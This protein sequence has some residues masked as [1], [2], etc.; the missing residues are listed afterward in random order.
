M[1]ILALPSPTTTSALSRGAH[2]LL[3]VL[4]ENITSSRIKRW[5]LV[6]RSYDEI[7]TGSGGHNVGGC[8]VAL[9]GLEGP[10]A[11]RCCA[12]PPR[13]WTGGTRHADPHGRG[14]SR[15][16]TAAEGRTGRGG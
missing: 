2:S 8:R 11:G 10:E 1:R 4:R 16:Q 7:K 13:G 9:T 12:T 3:L 6:D 5:H 15:G 14:T